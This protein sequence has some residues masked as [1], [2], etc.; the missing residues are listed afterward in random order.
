MGGLGRKSGLFS[1][2]H[3]TG[4]GCEVGGEGKGYVITNGNYRGFSNAQGT[5]IAA[6]LFLVG[7]KKT[8]IAGGRT[9]FSAG[10]SSTYESGGRETYHTNTEDTI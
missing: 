6:P 5:S 7:G 9:T 4:L 1:E 10:G 8:F 3:S 2:G